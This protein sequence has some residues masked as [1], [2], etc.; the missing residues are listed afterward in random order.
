MPFGKTT[1]A[2]MQFGKTTTTNKV[3]TNHPVN[4][5]CATEIYFKRIKRLTKSLQI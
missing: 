4:D 5:F 2:M 3:R 1:N